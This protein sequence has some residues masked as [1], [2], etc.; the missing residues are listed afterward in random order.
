M[1]ES[2]ARFFLEGAAAG[3]LGYAV[4]ALFFAVLNLI[5]GR[6]AFYT[7]ALLGAD[8]FYGLETPADL[9]IEPGPVFAYNGVH[10]LG[11]M[12]VGLFMRWL[13]GLAERIPQGWYL[14]LVLFLIVM[15]HLFGLPIWFETAV[16]AEIS[17]WYVV[18]ATSAAALAMAGFFLALH[19]RLRASMREYS[20]E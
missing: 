7:A 14:V 1:N 6:S 19:P 18:L 5:Q 20:D 11:F 16:V 17:L 9:V 13:V 4:V 12:A 8:L 10:I 3:L 2:R 15:P